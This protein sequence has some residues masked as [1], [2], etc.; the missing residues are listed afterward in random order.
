M[1][2][3]RYVYGFDM[4]GH[5]VYGKDEEDYDRSWANPLTLKQA[6]KG[7]KTLLPAKGERMAIYKLVPVK[8]VIAK[9]DVG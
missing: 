4:P 3:N 7:L 1:K 9:E 8:V 2:K 6:E 5:C